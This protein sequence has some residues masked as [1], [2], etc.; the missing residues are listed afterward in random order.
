ML[1]NSETNRWRSGRPT[2]PQGHLY[3]EGVVIGD[4]SQSS[5]RLV[6]SLGH[7]LVIVRP[8]VGD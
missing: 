8:P 6:R 4:S 3:T 2:I 7:R 5:W 1:V